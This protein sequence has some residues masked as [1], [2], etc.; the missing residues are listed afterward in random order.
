VKEKI[1]NAPKYLSSRK[2][3]EKKK[4]KKTLRRGGGPKARLANEKSGRGGPQEKKQRVVAEV[5]ISSKKAEEKANMIEH[6]TR[7]LSFQKRKT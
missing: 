6:S 3:V 2:S 5:S 7:R 1:L 4:K